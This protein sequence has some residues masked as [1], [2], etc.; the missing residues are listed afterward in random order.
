MKK[1][2]SIA[3]MGAY[4]AE[5]RAAG[6]TLGLVTTMGA[7]HLGQEELIRAATKQ[8]DVVIVSIFVNPLQ[9]GP[10]ET[11]ANYPRSFAEDLKLCEACGVQC[12]FA[13]AET[14]FYPRGYSTFVTEE[15][16][17]KPLCGLSRP[18]HFRGVATLMVK[19]FSIIRPH[20]AFFGQKTA[21]RAAV[22][23]KISED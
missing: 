12:V 11:I 20:Y 1:I 15:I 18:A 2:E 9:F 19:L 14:E 21:Q 8:A 6:Q 10:N 16:L 22:V 3:E 4:A 23:R 5:R 7:L 13:P 17:A